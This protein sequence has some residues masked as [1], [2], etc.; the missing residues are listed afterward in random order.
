MPKKKPVSLIPGERI[1]QSILLIRSQK[2]ML[3]T[4]LAQPYDVES[5]VLEQAVKRNL[6]R[7]PEDFM[8][9]LTK[10]ES[11]ALGTAE[12]QLRLFLYSIVERSCVVIQ[13]GK[14]VVE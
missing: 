10:D 6:R 4:D 13:F 11:D 9:Q 12:K 14:V 8:F 2:V 3:D 5:K 1:E 7:F